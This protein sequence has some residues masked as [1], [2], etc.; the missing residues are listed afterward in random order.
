MVSLRLVSNWILLQRTSSPSSADAR[1]EWAYTLDVHTNAFFPL[2]LELYVLQLFL[3]P[4]ILSYDFVGGIL[5][6]NTLYLLA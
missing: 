5:L 3:S 1:V 4:L 2:Y 6:G